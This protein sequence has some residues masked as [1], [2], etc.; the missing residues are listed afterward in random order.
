MAAYGT[1]QR[2]AEVSIM[3]GTYIIIGFIDI[4]ISSNSIIIAHLQC[5]KEPTGS[6]HLPASRTTGDGGGGVCTVGFLETKENNTI[7]LN[8]Y[9][10]DSASYR[11][12]GN[13]TAIKIA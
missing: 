9:G 11:I 7:Y 8:S 5:A 10:Y 3:P 4:T 13:L 2:I 6:Y 1:T 12:R